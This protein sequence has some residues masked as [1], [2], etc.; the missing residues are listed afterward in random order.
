M[1]NELNW[2][3]GVIV[4]IQEKIELPSIRRAESVAFYSLTRFMDEVRLRCLNT[5]L[6]NS[7][8]SSRHAVIGDDMP[9]Y[10]AYLNLKAQ[11]DLCQAETKALKGKIMALAAEIL[12]KEQLRELAMS[13]KDTT[14]TWSDQTG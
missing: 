9:R 3:T 11:G 6:N 1:D 7:V 10:E 12:D 4:A 8:C 5:T 13:G 14:E 2:F